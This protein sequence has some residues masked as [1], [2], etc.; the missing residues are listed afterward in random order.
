MTRKSVITKTREN[1]G[2]NVCGLETTKA[3]V[4]NWIIDDQGNIHRGIGDHQGN[5]S[6]KTGNVQGNVNQKAIG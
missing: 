5:A 6:I 4:M 1:Q 3:E 2:K